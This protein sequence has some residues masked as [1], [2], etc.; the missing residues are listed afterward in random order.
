MNVNKNYFQY[1]NFELCIECVAVL[2]WYNFWILELCFLYQLYIIQLYIKKLVL[3]T[4][5]TGCSYIGII[6]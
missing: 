6:D 2:G 3:H 1:Q 5:V 4:S